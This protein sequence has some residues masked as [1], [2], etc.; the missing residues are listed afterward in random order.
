MSPGKKTGRQFVAYANLSSQR[1]PS[2]SW[3]SI[4]AIV[5]SPD[6]FLVEPRRDWSFVRLPAQWSPQARH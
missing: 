3:S 4:S 1:L 5:A 2:G 6:E